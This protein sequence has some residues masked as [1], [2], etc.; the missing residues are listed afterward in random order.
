MTWW[1][2]WDS[3][4]SSGWWSHFWFWFGIACLFALG[5]AEIVSHIYGLH[6]DE[7][8]AAAEGAAAAQ[9]QA[10]ADAAEKRRKADVEGVQKQ[11]TEANKKVSELDR[12]RQPRHLTDD[13]KAKLGASLRG[14][15]VGTLAIKASAMADDALAYAEEISNFLQRL[16]WTCRIDNA[17]MTGSDVGGIWLAIRD[18]NHIPAAT[19]PLQHAFEAAGLPIHKT[20]NLEAGGPDPD[21]IWLSIGARK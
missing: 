10:D 21:E 8:V 18:Q 4:A 9:R 13:E 19:A 17:I 20:V 16:G 11:L 5:G 15:P 14:Q 12:L 3:I 1:P 6:K 7:L 2:G